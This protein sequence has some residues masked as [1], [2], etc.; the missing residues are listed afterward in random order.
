MKKILFLSIALLFGCTVF[1]QSA[2]DYPQYPTIQYKCE[3]MC[4]DH[5]ELP[6]WAIL[7]SAQMVPDCFPPSFYGMG[8]EHHP[9]P[10]VQGPNYPTIKYNPEQMRPNSPAYPSV[11]YPHRRMMLPN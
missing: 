1:A 10:F 2:V 4:P 8:K 6:P 9:T 5:N 3:Q 11:A 7:N